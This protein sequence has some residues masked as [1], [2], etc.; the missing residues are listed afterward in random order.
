MTASVVLCT[1]VR[2]AADSEREAVTPAMLSLAVTEGD[3]GAE[4]GGADCGAL[5]GLAIACGCT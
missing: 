3:A 2:G 4:D 5:A 1:L